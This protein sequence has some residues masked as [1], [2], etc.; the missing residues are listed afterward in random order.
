MVLPVVIPSPD[1]IE[2]PCFVGLD[3]DGPLRRPR[4]E[5][6]TDFQ[7]KTVQCR[8]V[9]ITHAGDFAVVDE[10]VAYAGVPTGS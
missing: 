10:D 3:P 6:A 8:K 1:K 7:T 5:S 2:T 4:H 9:E